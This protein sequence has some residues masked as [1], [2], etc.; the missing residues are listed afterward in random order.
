MKMMIK[1][2][3]CHVPLLIASVIHFLGFLKL[4]DNPL[5]CVFGADPNKKI[6]I[7]QAAAFQTSP[8]PRLISAIGND[9]DWGKKKQKNNIPSKSNVVSHFHIF[10]LFHCGTFGNSPCQGTNP[11]FRGFTP[12]LKNPLL[13]FQV[14]MEDGFLQFVECLIQWTFL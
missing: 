8:C 2:T 11:P 10:I 12:S 9:T 7:M 13:E 6:P 1:Y 14:W 5:S 4:D 3:K